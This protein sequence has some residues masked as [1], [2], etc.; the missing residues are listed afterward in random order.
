VAALSK[1]CFCSHSLVETAGSDLAGGGN[2]SCESCVVSVI[3]LCDRLIPRLEEYYGVCV[4]LD[5]DRMQQEAPTPTI[6]KQREVRL[7]NK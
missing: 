1:A 6:N 2:I 3:S 7:I 4:C 5:C